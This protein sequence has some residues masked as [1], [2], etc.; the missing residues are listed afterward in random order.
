MIIG[1]TQVQDQSAHWAV[2][3][4]DSV[5]DNG[6]FM[7]TTDVHAPGHQGP[8]L[9][10]AQAST[11]KMATEIRKITNIFMIVSDFISPGATGPLTVPHSVAPL[12]LR[13]DKRLRTLGEE[14][15]DQV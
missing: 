2:I 15:E 12:D 11:T 6:I 7:L 14:L 10:K 1:G 8:F 13:G 3:C 5:D 9:T 4:Y